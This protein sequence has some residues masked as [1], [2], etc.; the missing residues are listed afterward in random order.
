MTFIKGVP[1]KSVMSS[2]DVDVLVIGGG[3][4]GLACAAHLKRSGLNIRLCERHDHLGGVIRTLREDGYLIETGPN[5][6]Y[7]RPEEPLLEFRSFLELSDQA[8]LAGETGK[9]RFVLLDGKPV[10]LPMSIREGLTTPLLSLKGKL[11]LLQEIWIPPLEGSQNEESV[12]EFV[13]RRLG[14]EFLDHFIDPFVKG[15]YASKPELLSMAA[16]FPRLTTMEDHYGSIIKGGLALLRS[17]K[18]RVNPLTRT[19]FSFPSGMGFLP[20]SLAKFLGSDAG[21]NAEVVGLTR[22]DSGYLVSLLYDEEIYYI[23]SRQIVIACGAPHT[24]DLLSVICP[25]ASAP[26]FDI[27]YAPVAVVYMG[28][29]RNVVSHPLDGFG[30]LVPESEKR[31]ILGVLFSSSL[32]PERAP[33]DHVLLTVFVGGMQSPKLAY[34]FD[35]DLLDFVQKEVRSILGTTKPPDFQRIQRWEGAIPQYTK[36]HLDR[37]ER[38]RQTLPDNIHLAGAYLEGVSVSQSFTSGI[39]A[40]MSVLKHPSLH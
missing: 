13:S 7:L 4:A 24:A 18:K 28:F 6:L 34:A 26:L 14:P 36:G 35:E 37:V 38:I 16:T 25:E 39:E 19:I 9:K 10:A 40:A 5:S 1:W 17:P 33:K 32:F 30:L 29:H 15:V 8:L 31:K 12:A 20:E 21:T 3:I 27:P 11:R 23:N 22:T 2:L